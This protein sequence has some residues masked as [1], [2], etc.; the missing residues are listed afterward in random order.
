MSKRTCSIAGCERSVYGHGWCNR[1]WKRWKR[2]GDPLAGG[3]YLYATPEEAFKARTVR[4]ESG[5]L[6]WKGA[7]NRNGY[8]VTYVDG[9]AILAHRYAWTRAN[10][11]IPDGLH[12]DHICGLPACCEPTHLRVVTV[13]QNA[14]NRIRLAAN[15]TSGYRGVYWSN[16][17]KKWFAKAKHKGKQFHGGFYDTPEEANEAA[18]ELRNRLFTHNN[19][20]RLDNAS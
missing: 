13:K 9:S 14:E 12:L 3:S 18:I 8:G 6:I 4:T 7:R 2:H 15:N 17:A 5:H 20:D 19:R 10:G 11:P 16:Q 1:H